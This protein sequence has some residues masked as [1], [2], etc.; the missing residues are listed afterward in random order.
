MYAILLLT[1]LTLRVPIFSTS[2]SS[3]FSLKHGPF[4][5]RL[6][7]LL[8]GALSLPTLVLINSVES[9]GVCLISCLIWQ[10]SHLNRP[11]RRLFP[12]LLGG[13]TKGG[14]QILASGLPILLH[15]ARLGIESKIIAMTRN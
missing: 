8:L 9:G 5:K 11:H 1:F 14:H 3:M 15:F 6:M 10:L 12:L 13:S 7:P 2:V 4:L